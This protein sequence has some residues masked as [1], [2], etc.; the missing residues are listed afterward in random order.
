MKEFICINCPMGCM[1]KVDDSDL[2]NIKV[3]GNTCKRGET[4]GINELLHPSR[5]VTSLVKVNNGESNVVSVKTTSAIPKELIYKS[6]DL[7]K[8]VSL[9]APLSIGD[10][11]IKNILN[12]NID[13]VVTKN[14]LRKE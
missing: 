13:F 8:D 5:M 9:D 12:T 2:S 6:L 7:L 10:I 4:Y 1:L 3:S 11:V 14:I